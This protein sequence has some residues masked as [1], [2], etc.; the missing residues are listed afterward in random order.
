MKV[1]PQSEAKKLIKVSGKMIL[2]LNLVIF[3]T[4][5]MKEFIT[6]IGFVHW[7]FN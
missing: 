6:L 1:V 3:I 4:P 7:L 5:N 2:L